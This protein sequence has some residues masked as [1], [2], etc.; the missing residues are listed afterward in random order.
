[1]KMVVIKTIS[2]TFL[3]QGVTFEN[4][5]ICFQTVKM[6]SILSFFINPKQCC[7]INKM[8]H[9]HTFVQ[10]SRACQMFYTIRIFCE[11][12]MTLNLFRMGPFRGCS[13]KGRQ[14]APLSPKPLTHILQS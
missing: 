10:W 5:K 3:R 6:F 8:I 14:K 1:M 4:G 7:Y 13:R 12:L 2:V 11:N 9:A